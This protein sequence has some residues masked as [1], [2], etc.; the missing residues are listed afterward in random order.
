M[1]LSF[2]SWAIPCLATSIARLMCFCKRKWVSW[3]ESNLSK[4]EEYEAAVV[5]FI[6]SLTPFDWLVVHCSF[7]VF[8]ILVTIIQIELCMYILSCNIRFSII[9]EF[10]VCMYN[11]ALSCN[12]KRY[13]RKTFVSNGSLSRAFHQCRLYK[14]ITLLTSPTSTRMLWYMVWPYLSW[15]HQH[16][17]TWSNVCSINSSPVKIK[18]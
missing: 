13:Y 10:L 1:D 11:P 16:Y 17:K 2:L 6:I 4:L 14:H 15:S 9:E 5:Q 18:R 7:K 12:M 8:E 3:R